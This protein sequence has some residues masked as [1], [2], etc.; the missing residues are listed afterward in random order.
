M[1]WLR[2]KRIG[3]VITDQLDVMPY[4]PRI[5]T[6]VGGISLARLHWIMP[7]I[8]D[9]PGSDLHYE[10][11]KPWRRYDGLVFLKAMGEKSHE[12]AHR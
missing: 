11:F 8:N 9:A 4:W 3:W 7:R 12:L 5:D 2:K 6:G 1:K 10:V